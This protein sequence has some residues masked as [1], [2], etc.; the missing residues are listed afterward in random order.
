MY[1]IKVNASHQFDVSKENAEA[2]DCIETS[3]NTFH[4]LQNNKS[5]KAAI[6]NSN[7][8]KKFYAIKVN[9]NLYEVTIN[10]S[11]DQQIEALG[12]EIGVSKQ[13]NNIKSPMP[14]LILEINVQVGQEVK[15]NESL[16]ILEAMKMEIVIN[17]PRDGIIKTISVNQGETV[18]KNSLLIEFE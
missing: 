9:N 8:L 4:I 12:F 13:V 5:V 16:L 6:L 17:S 10:D 1:K 7:F 15:E 11:L 2:L 18:D 14:G 3:D